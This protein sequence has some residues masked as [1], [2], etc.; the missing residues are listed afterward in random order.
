VVEPGSDELDL[1]D[2]NSPENVVN[3]LLASA[4]IVE[5]VNQQ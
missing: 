3:E 1:L 4:R 2:R 5:R